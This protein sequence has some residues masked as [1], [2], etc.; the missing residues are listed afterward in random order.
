ME[1]KDL[2]EDA[3]KFIELKEKE[4]EESETKATAETKKAVAKKTAGFE[5]VLVNYP[6]LV[7]EKKMS[8][9]TRQACFMVSSGTF[10]IKESTKK[11]ER[12]L[13]MTVETLSKFF[14]GL[15]TPLPAPDNFWIS[16]F[17]SGTK[18]AE[19]LMSYLEN[20][21]ILDMMRHHAFVVQTMGDYYKTLQEYCYGTD[22]ERRELMPLVAIRERKHNPISAYKLDKK[23][24]SK[25][26]QNDKLYRFMVSGV[27][28]MLIDYFSISNMKQFLEDYELSLAEFRGNFGRGYTQ[29]MR[30]LLEVTEFD[31]ASF[32]DYILYNSV[33]QGHADDLVQFI[34]NWTDT[35]D[36]Q[37]KLYG[38]IKEKYP[39]SLL[40]L[41][42]QLAYKSRMHDQNQY[43][44]AIEEIYREN[45]HYELIVNDLIFTLPQTSMDMVDE[46]VQ[47]D[48]CLA[49]YVE[50]HA[51]KECLIL[52]AR[53]TT[54]PDE[55]YITLEIRGG[56]YNVTQALYK[57]NR[58]IS[59]ED[60]DT[61][62]KW[63]ATVK[64]NDLAA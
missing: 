3:K 60:M 41:H 18:F 48:S 49:S 36:M 10:F 50:K 61:I 44:E 11:E 7:I 62:D 58:P 8:T 52:F 53:K 35:L 64:E 6:D 23:S 25:Y 38:K 47:Q 42:N 27:Y 43:D 24:Y 51:K 40:L 63:I 9:M 33:F 54:N 12:L 59:L 4:L 17:K 31:F 32:S 26:C 57:G 5:Y 20:G 30:R 55:S 14:N 29:I 28:E 39:K 22:R 37:K 13:E 56:K 1:I 45:R 2:I 19:G 34:R 16:E 46:A 21:D 15:S